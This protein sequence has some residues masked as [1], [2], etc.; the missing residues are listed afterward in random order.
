[1]KNISWADERVALIEGVAVA[2]GNQ[3]IHQGQRIMFPEDLRQKA[4]M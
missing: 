2:L 3:A 1:M 4:G